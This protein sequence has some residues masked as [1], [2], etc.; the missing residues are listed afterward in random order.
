MATIMGKV[1]PTLMTGDGHQTAVPQ[2]TMTVV[3]AV[4]LSRKI[5]NEKE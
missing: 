5:Q 1:I 4:L 3:Q 2:P